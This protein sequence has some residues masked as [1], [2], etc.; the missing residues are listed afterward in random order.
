MQDSE[1][2]LS[3]MMPT[4]NEAA[5]LSR[6]IERVLVRPEVGELIVVDDASSDGTWQILSELAAREPRIKA[7]RQPN[8]QG[9]GAA[10]RRA[11]AELDRPYAVVQ[12]ADL[13]VDPDDY[14]HL[15]KPLLEGRADA[16]FGSRTFRVTN[17]PSLIH[18]LGNRGLTLATNLIFWGRVE[19]ME[20][21]YKLLPSLLWQT[22]PLR[23]MRFEFEPE[24]TVQLLQ[25]RARI[26]NVPIRYEPRTAA[27]GKKIGMR[28]GWQAL[29]YLIRLRFSTNAQAS[30]EP[31]GRFM[32]PL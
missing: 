28:D 8:N 14:P 15:L 31:P 30:P 2:L 16:A 32:R 24:V 29:A 6:A 9:K 1:D 26:A 13:E 12:D 25:R 20:T 21:C 27:Q 4:Y 3:V 10:V 19:D 5:T 17:V 7:F 11:I 23:A 18:M 22:L